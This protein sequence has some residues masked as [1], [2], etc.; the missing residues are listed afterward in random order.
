MAEQNASRFMP[1]ELLSS[2]GLWICVQ[3]FVSICIGAERINEI[4]KISPPHQPLCTFCALFLLEQTVLRWEKQ[5]EFHLS[6]IKPISG[7]VWCLLHSF[8]THRHGAALTNTQSYIHTHTDSP[9]KAPL[10]RLPYCKGHNMEYHQDPHH[11][12]VCV[13]V[14]VFLCRH[15]CVCVCVGCE[16]IFTR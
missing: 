16:W 3:V 14:W 10:P 9:H 13:Y 2:L 8:H 11:Y 12:C 1:I 4:F 7:G 5:Q 15:V 6:L